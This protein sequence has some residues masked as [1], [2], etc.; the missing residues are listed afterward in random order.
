MSSNPGTITNLLREWSGGRPDAMD[1][2]LPLVYQQ[3]RGLARQRLAAE[4]EG[5]PWRPTEL[6]HE[7]YL[8]LLDSDVSAKDRSHFYI[9]CSQVMRRILIDH[10]RER[11]R[12]K[13][14]GGAPEVS[15][16][17]LDVAAAGSP[18]RLLL[19]HEALDKLAEVDARKARAVELVLFGGLELD[20]AAEALGVSNATVRRDVKAGKAWLYNAILNSDPPASAR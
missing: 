9:I 13:R 5:H 10:A 14:G 16:A 11:L 17:S 1:R 18:E 12:L 19:I 4:N 3:L 20:A 15:L 7:A 8:R 2:L 6:V